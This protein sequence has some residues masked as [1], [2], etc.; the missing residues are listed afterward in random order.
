MY[1][2]SICIPIYNTAVQSLVEAL[3][4]KETSFLK[5]ILLF[6]DGS[7][8]VIKT[9]NKA[10]SS[11]PKVDY[12][13]MPQ[14]LGRSK[15]RNRLGKAAQ[16]DFLLFIDDDCTPEK[17]NF[18]QQYATHFED[19]EVL[20]GGHI[21]PT[22]VKKGFELHQ[23][24]GKHSEVKAAE[25]RNEHPYGAFHSSNFCIKRSLFLQTLFNEQLTQ[26]GHEDTLFGFELKQAEVS[27]QHINNPVIHLGIQTNVVFMQKTEKALQ[28][29]AYLYKNEDAEFMQSVKLLRAYS[30]IKRLGVAK[31]LAAYHNSFGDSIKR[32]LIEKKPN[33][34]WYNVFKISYL[35]WF[36]R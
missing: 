26:Y 29:L 9:Q 34:K 13:E 25:K 23:Y 31:V 12:Q 32:K 4:Q 11:L 33:T 30:G 28:N 8:D 35:C 16:G 27:L 22:E 15:I 21:Y 24:I 18:L 5:E 17:E 7:E 3:L 14:N 20:C 1:T 36:L 10:L 6:D 19:A 2:L